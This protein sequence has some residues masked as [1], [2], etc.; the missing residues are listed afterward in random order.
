MTHCHRVCFGPP[1][2]RCTGRR[3]TRSAPCAFARGP[4]TT[5]AKAALVRVRPQSF[6]RP[7]SGR[8]QARR[9][10]F[11]APPLRASPSP[12]R[13]V[14]LARVPQAPDVHLLQPRRK[15]CRDRHRSRTWRRG[16]VHCACKWTDA[17]RG[18]SIGHGT[19]H[20][21]VPLRPALPRRD[22]RRPAAQHGLFFPPL[23]AASGRPLP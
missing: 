23:P 13:C 1:Q 4:R 22:R 6:S 20:L 12:D 10:F 17:N 19:R 5:G 8:Q 3:W 7:R 21:G 18:R 16:L 2:R 15:D 14:G 9:R 11:C